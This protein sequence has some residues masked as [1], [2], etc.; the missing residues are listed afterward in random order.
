MLSLTS[1]AALPVLKTVSIP[2]NVS[3]RQLHDLAADIDAIGSERV[4]R[5]VAAEIGYRTERYLA[6]LEAYRCHRFRRHSAS[7]AVVW[8]DGATRLL[9]YGR[10]ATAPT[11]LVVPSL[12]NRYHVLD[13]LPER[14]FLQHLASSGLRPL[15]IDW[16]A[17]GRQERH[18]DLVD[19]IAGPLEAAFEAARHSAN[20][21]VGVVGY[22][23][24]GL[25]AL[26]LSRSRYVASVKSP[27]LR[28]S[29]RLGI[30]MPKVGKVS[31]LPSLP[32]AS[33]ASAIG[34]AVCRSRRSK[35]CSM[36]SIRLPRFANSFGLQ[37]STPTATML[38][39]SLPSRTG[40]TTECPCPSGWR[41]AVRV[42]GTEITNLAKVCGGSQA[43]SC[44][45]RL[46]ADLPLS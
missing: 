12:I 27:V 44:A 36:S 21:P 13:L 23:M 40:S 45:P 2:S 17:P 25:L 29:R 11:V 35:L 9:D 19:Y 8:H 6:G 31:A 7:R 32:T 5:A 20:G 24:G 34:S 18:F 10:D 22:C 41:A 43:R 46:C 26:A 30:F 16:Q 14:S 37:V 4:E 28:C 38:A 42:P 1:R 3:G 39:V 33:R 15:V